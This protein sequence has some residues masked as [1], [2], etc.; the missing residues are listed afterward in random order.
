MGFEMGKQFVL[1]A[2]EIRPLAPG[3][4]SCIATDRITVDGHPVGYMYR[5]K[6]HNELDS[7]WRFFAGDEPEEYTEQP[8]NFELYDVNTIANYDPEIVQLL[9]APIGSAYRRGDSGKL[10]PANQ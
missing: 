10:I 4:G 7:G 9:G 2:A 8:A 3:P 1:D 5:E 6:P